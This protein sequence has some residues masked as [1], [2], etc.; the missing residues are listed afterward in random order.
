[1]ADP[2]SPSIL[3]GLIT[4]FYMP[5]F[6]HTAR[7]LTEEERAVV[8][9]RVAK[10]RTVTSTIDTRQLQQTLLSAKV[11][12][13]CLIYLCIGTALFKSAAPRSPHRTRSHRTRSARGGSTTTTTT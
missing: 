4:C 5:T 11:W 1:M 13:F 6:P 9:S 7:W 3:F 8:E 10:Q 12:A 2:G